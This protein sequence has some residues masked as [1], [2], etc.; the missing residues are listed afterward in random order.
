VV[1]CVVSYRRPAGL[2]RLLDGLAVQEF[3]KSEV[4][5][6]SV[7]VVDNDPD[8]SAAGV[9]SAAKTVLP[10]PIEYVQE[11][12]RGIPYARN[13]AVLHVQHSADFIAFVD[14][15]EVPTP[16]WLDELLHIQTQ[17]QADVV[18]G[19][20]LAQ[21]EDSPP[22]WVVRGGFFDRGRHQNGSELTMAR[23][24]NVLI[25]TPVFD[26]MTPVFAEELA[27]TG[28]SDTHFFLR[29]G[30]AGYRIVW[31]DDAVIQEWQPGSR[32]TP[33]YV[34]RR[35]FRNGNTRGICERKLSGLKAEQAVGSLGAAWWIAKGV[36]LLPVAVFR[37]THAVLR[38]LRNVCTGA[39]YFAG[40]LGFQFDGY[41]R[42]DGS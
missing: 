3:V 9:C 8:G 20:V 5:A 21:F 19:P 36:G 34:L 25:R 31:A 12:R 27:L 24:G 41:R 38:S 28:G 6:L 33:A 39:G 26:G 16:R 40:R 10:W 32:L 4:P 11:A 13:A 29:V 15:D 1:V 37:G 17:H 22:G 30:R 7:L 14:D 23:T 35:G 42:T 18:T 2:T